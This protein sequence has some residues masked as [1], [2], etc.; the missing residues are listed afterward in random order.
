MTNEEIDS[1]VAAVLSVDGELPWDEAVRLVTILRR[2][3]VLRSATG[4]RSIEITESIDAD[5]RV[6]IEYEGGRKLAGALRTDIHIP[7]FGWSNP[8][9]PDAS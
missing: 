3:E 7:A 2:A 6:S 5:P 4:I 9:L 8:L 1:R